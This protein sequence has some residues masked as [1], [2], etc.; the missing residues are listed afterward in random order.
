MT[1][2]S[3]AS[4]ITRTPKP[5]G[6]QRRCNWEFPLSCKFLTHFATNTLNLKLL[7]SCLFSHMLPSPHSGW[8]FPP[9]A[10]PAQLLETM[11]ISKAVE[12]LIGLWAQEQHFTGVS[13]RFCILCKLNMQ[14]M[15]YT[16]KE[17][18]FEKHRTFWFK[19]VNMLMAFSGS[20][21]SSPV[22]QQV[23]D[24][25]METLCGRSPKQFHAG[26]N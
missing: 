24:S 26:V 9:V 5:V 18:C 19:S 21:G 14:E 25:N 3:G 20:Q 6:S 4:P 13:H 11:G 2:Y 22:Q 15:K 8:V 10:L 7:H 23:F 1:C 12:I 16:E 17:N